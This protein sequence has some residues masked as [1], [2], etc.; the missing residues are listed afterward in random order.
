MPDLSFIVPYLNKL[1]AERGYDVSIRFDDY[2][3]LVEYRVDKSVNH[4]Q[5]ALPYSMCDSVGS[6]EKFICK[7]IDI[8]IDNFKK[9]F[10]KEETAVEFYE[11]L[12]Q[13]EKENEHD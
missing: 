4:V 5:G 11:K 9:H 10:E 3:Q 13:E 1:K 7:V 6:F 8:A 12:T 2:H